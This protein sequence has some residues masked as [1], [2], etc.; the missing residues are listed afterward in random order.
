M[1]RADGPPETRSLGETE[2]VAG[3]AAMS[4]SGKYG[5]TRHCAG[6]IG[7]VDLRA[8]GARAQG[9]F[10]S[11][12][13]SPQAAAFAASATAPPGTLTRACAS[14]PPA[15]AK[16]LYLD[17]SFPRGLR[18]AGRAQ[19]HLRGLDLPHPAPAIVVSLAAASPRRRRSS[20][21]MS[22]A[23]SRSA[24]MPARPRRCSR[25]GAGRIQKLG[26]F[27]NCLDE[28]G[29]TRHALADGV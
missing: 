22:A 26:Q 18:G 2:F 5:A 6:I 21:T 20:S 10:W 24:P 15:R 25:N 8:V 29:R 17:R 14:L 1:Y 3:V 9:A 12:T 23:R 7:N 28:A 16:G 13:S 11:S 19:P 4:D 27:P